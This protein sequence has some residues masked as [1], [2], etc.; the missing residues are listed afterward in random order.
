MV[1]RISLVVMLAIG[2]FAT[3]HAVEAQQ[4]GK[5][6]QIGKLVPGRPIPHLEAAFEQGL[7]AMRSKRVSSRTSGDPVGTSPGSPASRAI[8]RRS[9][10]DCFGKLRRGLLASRS[11][12]T[13]VIHTASSR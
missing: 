5:V 13:R 4:A 9:A 2:A 7:R 10:S 1:L 8:S 11:S 6:Y 3:L 12:T